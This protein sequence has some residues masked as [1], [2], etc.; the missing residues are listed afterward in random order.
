MFI[1][2]WIHVIIQPNISLYMQCK[3]IKNWWDKCNANSMNWSQFCYVHNP[4]ISEDKKK[5]SQ[6]KWWQNRTLKLEHSLPKIDITSTDHVVLL[7]SD[8]INRV[9]SGELDIKTANCLWV[10]SGH[11]LKA[12]ENAEVK[13]KMEKLEQLLKR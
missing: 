12:L 11:L 6:A 5:L 1:Y 3:F 2:N 4:K 9:R 7:L 8:T 10:L 13:T